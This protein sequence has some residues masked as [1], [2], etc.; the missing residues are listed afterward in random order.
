MPYDPCD[1]CGGEDCCVCSVYLERQ[2]DMKAD[3]EDPHRNWC[4]DCGQDH[5]EC[6]DYEFDEPDEDEEGEEDEYDY[7]ENRY[8][9]DEE[10]TPMGQEYGDGFDEAFYG[11]D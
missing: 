5:C 8:G 2:A 11:D 3:Q 1:G 9:N 7:A 4:P 6:N 10:D